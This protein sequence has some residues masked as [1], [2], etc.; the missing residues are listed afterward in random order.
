MRHV[1]AE[2]PLGKVADVPHARLD[3]ELRAQELVDRPGLLG[4]LDDD[5]GVASAPR[6]RAASPAPALG[7]G[8]LG[9][10][11]S[12]RSSHACAEWV[13][14]GFR[15]H[16]SGRSLRT[17][18]PRYLPTYPLPYFTASV[19]PSRPVRTRGPGVIE[20]AL[21]K[22]PGTISLGRPSSDPASFL[23]SD[24]ARVSGRVKGGAH[25]TTPRRPVLPAS[26]NPMPFEVFRRHQRKLL[27]IF[28]ILAMFGFVVSDSLPAAA[29]LELL[30]VGTRRSPSSTVSRSTR[31]SSTR[32]PGSETGPIL[33]ISGLGQFMSRE[34]FGGLKQRD[35]VDALILQHE[36]DRLGH[37]RRPPRSGGNG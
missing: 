36:A 16:S 33:F 8:L 20:V 32:W 7:R 24:I 29:Q 14:W 15:F 35:L 21:G 10:G 9:D 26:R 1:H 37:S 25:G 34:I 2:L 12:I 6:V 28:A 27:A 31:A 23:N 17:F 13:S 11:T 22:N 3:D 30:A 5:Q 19:D 18:L 4:A